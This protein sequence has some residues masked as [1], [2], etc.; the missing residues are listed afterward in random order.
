MI[1]RIIFLCIPVLILACNQ[2]STVNGVDVFERDGTVSLQNGLTGVEFDLRSG[3]Y[4]IRDVKDGRICI[5]SVCARVNDWKTT[6]DAERNWKA[7]PDTA[8]LSLL[9]E[10]TVARDK[11]ILLRFSLQNDRP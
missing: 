7:V 9:I 8:G 6:D 2:K 5:D 3:Y 1:K 4:R 10:N 11:T